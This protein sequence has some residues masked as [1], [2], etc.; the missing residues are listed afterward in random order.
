MPRE[1][2]KQSKFT[3]NHLGTK[4]VKYRANNGKKMQDKTDETPIVMQ[5]KGE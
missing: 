4:P 2:D 1:H 5:T 3:P